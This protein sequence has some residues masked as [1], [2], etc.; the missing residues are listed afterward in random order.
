AM[1]L[2]CEVLRKYDVSNDGFIDFH[3]F[4]AMMCPT[5]YRPPEMCGFDQEVLGSLVK[6]RAA[7]MRSGLDQQVALYESPAD[8]KAEGVRKSEMPA[9]MRP[10]CQKRPGRPGTRSSTAWTTTGIIPSPMRS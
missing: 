7:R 4:V 1:S 3:E 6:M 10:E 9:S 2:D 8:A 5:E